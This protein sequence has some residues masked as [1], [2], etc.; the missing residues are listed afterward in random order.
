MADLQPTDQ[1]LVNRADSTQTVEH[2]DLM[3]SLQDTDLML[4]NRSDQ[5]YTITG[6]DLKDSLV[7]AL[8]LTIVLSTNDPVVGDVIT[9]TPVASGGTPPYNFTYE[10]K[11]DGSTIAGATSAAFIPTDSEIG[12]ALVCSV[13]VT[14]D[15]SETLTADSG[16]T[17]PVVRGDSPPTLTGV[18]LAGGP[19]FSDQTY[20]STLQNYDPGQP[21]ATLTMKAKVVGALS[22]IGETSNIDNVSTEQAPTIVSEWG[23]N[24]EPGYVSLSDSNT[25]AEKTS[26]GNGYMFVTALIDVPNEGEPAGFLIFTENRT[27]D[28]QGWFIGDEQSG[29]K[30][31]S[32]EQLDNKNNIGMRSDRDTIGLQKSFASANGKSTGDTI[33]GFISISMPDTGVD[34]TNR[35][36]FAK[37]GGKIKVWCQRLGASDWIK[38]GNPD[39]VTSTPSF[40]CPDGPLYLGWM[41][42]SQGS[43]V[44]LDG[45]S[46]L[47]VL[48]LADGKDLTN[49]LFQPGDY[50]TMP[51]GE[52]PGSTGPFAGARI[53]NSYSTAYNAGS[54]FAVSSADE[55]KCTPSGMLMFDKEALGDTWSLTFTKVSGEEFNMFSADTPD[56]GFVKIGGG[57]SGPITVNQNDTTYQRFFKV[58]GAGSGIITYKVTGTGNSEVSGTVDSIVL[59]TPPKMKLTNASAGWTAGNTAKNTVANPILGVIETDVIVGYTDELVAPD[60]TYGGKVES[61]FSNLDESYKMFNNEASSAEGRYQGRQSDGSYVGYTRVYLPEG[62]SGNLRVDSSYSG[63]STKPSQGVYYMTD[64]RSK[65]RAYAGNSEF[66][67]GPAANRGE[68]RFT[69]SS[70]TYIEV[71]S[72]Y[73]SM[74]SA[75]WGVYID[76]VQVIYTRPTT[77]ARVTLAT[78]LNLSEFVED[79]PV[80]QDGGDYQPVTSQITGT[81]TSGGSG[82]GVTTQVPNEWTQA[83]SGANT[84]KG[85][86]EILG[87][88][89]STYDENGFWGKL[90][91]GGSGVRGIMHY[92][93]IT[94]GD[95][96][97]LYLFCGSSSRYAYGDVQE[98]GTVLELPTGK[99][100]GDSAEYVEVTASKESGTFSIDFSSGGATVFGITPASGLVYVEFENDKDLMNFRPG[101]ELQGGNPGTTGPFAGVRRSTKDYNG[102]YNEATPI[103]IRDGSNWN[104]TTTNVLFFDLDALGTSFDLTFTKTDSN[105]E[106]FQIYSTDDPNA[107]PSQIFSSKNSPYNITYD[108]YQGDGAIKRY[109]LIY[110]TGSAVLTYTIT[111]TGASK[112][113][114]VVR[115][116]PTNNRLFVSGGEWPNSNTVTGPV[117]PPGAGV[118]YNTDPALNQLIF[119][120]QDEEN[121]RR[122]IAGQGNVVIGPASPGTAATGY[123]TWSGSDVTGYTTSDPGYAAAPTN[124]ELSFSDP[125]PAGLTWDQELPAGTTIQTIVEASNTQGT[126][127]SGWSNTVIGRS[128]TSED[129]LAEAAA[130]SQAVIATHENRVAV[131]QGEQA[132]QKRNDLR[133]NLVEAGFSPGALQP[134]LGKKP[135]T[136]GSKKD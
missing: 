87:Q 53:S 73:E 128:L 36:A 119:K 77:D 49:G 51:G 3:A 27:N 67:E 68:F 50:V 4:I 93:G 129:N 22:G 72:D 86:P 99:N 45:T 13:T 17:N 98:A 120:S 79:D 118:V 18:S 78:N 2:S 130:V 112:N 102:S 82:N 44:S 61:T 21:E 109:F 33:S 32:P 41:F 28:Y 23:F 56:G 121:N 26:G 60:Y 133:S 126:V 96:I 84:G 123:L 95:K 31:T 58:Y 55:F 105:T 101:D 125:S 88:T 11:A 117:C 97:R 91:D 54:P 16:A 83:D 24:M 90:P 19:R 80:R 52:T 135:K 29:Y 136:K 10:W 1:F 108:I 7:P 116:D 110:G 40:Y 9:A 66:T 74:V 106:K 5:T 35:F 37:N 71:G 65:K 6:E 12:A 47:T 69:D 94:S 57:S 111:G 14:D 25:K 63:S 89:P 8:E 85:W 113:P 48:E 42:Y 15:A 81:G 46:E 122:F 104:S 100:F 107:S 59:S 127:N 132:M 64:T 20:T 124:L 131:H 92:E 34:Y 62:H 43:K 134:L 103:D 39:D 76:E 70:A 114:T 115:T 38:G 75:I 30:L